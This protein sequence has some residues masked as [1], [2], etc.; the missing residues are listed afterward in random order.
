MS[1]NQYE[2]QF[3]EIRRWWRA[4]KKKVIEEH[5]EELDDHAREQVEQG[6]ARGIQGGQL[7]HDVER[8]GITY[9]Y[10]GWWEVKEVFDHE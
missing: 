9:H 1:E 10:E 8:K 2:R 3:K 7:L 6:R 5:K 4:N